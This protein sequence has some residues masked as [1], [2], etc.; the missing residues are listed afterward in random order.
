MAQPPIEVFG[1]HFGCRLGR[2]FGEKNLQFNKRIPFYYNQINLQ[3]PE[4]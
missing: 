3:M 4:L 1:H 2:H